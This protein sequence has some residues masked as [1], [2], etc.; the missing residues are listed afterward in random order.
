MNWHEMDPDE[1]VKTR[2]T[3][4]LRDLR[5]RV[6]EKEVMRETLGRVIKSHCDGPRHITVKLGFYA[7]AFDKV[8]ARAHRRLIHVHEVVPSLKAIVPDEKPIERSELLAL[9]NAVALR[10]RGNLKA[11]EKTIDEWAES[12]ADEVAGR[13]D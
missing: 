9:A 4:K 8:H 6:G 7:S 5:Q 11:D 3:P 2:S 12:L 13:D 1:E 10:R